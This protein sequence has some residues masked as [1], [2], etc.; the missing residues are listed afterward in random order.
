MRTLTIVLIALLGLVLLTPR[1]ANAILLWKLLD[2]G[3]RQPKAKEP[4]PGPNGEL[5]KAPENAKEREEMKLKLEGEKF[6]FIWD[7][8]LIGDVFR[9][10][11]KGYVD[12]HGILN[13]TDDKFEILSLKES[14]EAFNLSVTLPRPDEDFRVPRT[15][16]DESTGVVS[17]S[18]YRVFTDKWMIWSVAGRT[19]MDKGDYPSHYLGYFWILGGTE[20]AILR[21]P[22][23]PVFFKTWEQTPEKEFICSLKNGEN[24]RVVETLP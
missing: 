14:F 5:P 17:V 20:N 15:R 9:I 3:H 19:G 21:A 16:P 12:D 23:F 22:G 11:C 4:A 8:R 10:R 18:S 7:D 24:W 1:P 2:R 13:I 6:P